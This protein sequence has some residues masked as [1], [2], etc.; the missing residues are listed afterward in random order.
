MKRESP[1]DFVRQAADNSIWDGKIL[2]DT[3]SGENQKVDFD[4]N[5]WQD[6]AFSSLGYG[7]FLY[8]KDQAG[9]ENTTRK[10]LEN[11]APNGI[12][13][14]FG[15]IMSDFLKK[16]DDKQSYDFLVPT[17]DPETGKPLMKQ[18]SGTYEE[19][20]KR[21]YNPLNKYGI[22]EQSDNGIVAA[23]K[24]FSNT[25]A[26]TD[27][28]LISAT[29]YGQD[30]LKFPYEAIANEKI[31]TDLDDIFEDTMKDTERRNF[32]D[33]K[34]ADKFGTVSWFMSGTGSSFASLLQFGGVGRGVRAGVSIAD[35]IGQRLARKQ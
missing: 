7:D 3:E 9:T 2:S 6:S 1:E 17:I 22:Q 24:G 29:K 8:V 34:D 12:G 23:L 18:V 19:V 35:A 32:L 16:F 13:N 5:Q 15:Q 30:L 21:G 26:E 20:A 31:T 10:D 27:D 4:P 25:A 11:Y 33:S 14:L 28:L